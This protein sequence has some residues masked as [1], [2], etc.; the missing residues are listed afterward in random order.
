MELEDF[1]AKFADQFE[2]T[3]IDEISVDTEFQEL[4][5]WS[6]LI[7]LSVIVMA[8]KEYHKE[9]TGKEIK[10]CSTVRSLFELIQ[11]K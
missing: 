7:A 4:D 9:I 1:I 3:E 6:S 5:E 10:A 2:D 11:N 8:N